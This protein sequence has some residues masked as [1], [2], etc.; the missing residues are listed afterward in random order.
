[1]KWYADDPGRRARQLAADVFTLLWIALWVVLALRLRDDVLRLRAPGDRMVDAGANLEG[2]FGAA[3]EHAARVPLLGESLARAFGR[4]EAAGTR[5]ETAGHSQVA[6]VET[7]ATWLAVVVI[8]VPVLMLLLVWLP[9]RLRY[10]REAAAVRQLADRGGFDDVLALRALTR[11]PARRLGRYASDPATAWRSGDPHA[12][13]ALAQAQL[14]ALGLRRR[15]GGPPPLSAPT[16]ADR[17]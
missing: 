6:A 11:L 17:P 15:P 5:L 14:D 13:A 10:A 2:A 3:A 8:V 16:G 9:A 7:T 4:G 12:V 1:M